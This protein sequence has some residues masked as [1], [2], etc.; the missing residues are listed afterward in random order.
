MPA[1][2]AYHVHTFA[3]RQRR[4]PP[5]FPKIHGESAPLQHYRTRCRDNLH[6]QMS[7]FLGHTHCVRC[8]CQL[9]EYAYPPF[10]SL[11]PGATL[12]QILLLQIRRRI[13]V[14]SESD[15]ASVP[16]EYPGKRHYF[17]HALT[18][19]HWRRL[20]GSFSGTPRM[21]A[22]HWD[23]PSSLR[24]FSKPVMASRAASALR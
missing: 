9:P 17:M 10:F 23:S 11:F 8:G 19:D 24:P 5:P 22:C 2:E 6:Q 3:A 1:K 20:T 4:D 18:T 14:Y 12:P 13:L 21:I 7:P 15:V 16:P